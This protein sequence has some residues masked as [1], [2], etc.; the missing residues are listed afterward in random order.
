L[1]DRLGGGELMRGQHHVLVP[2]VAALVIAAGLLAT[3]GP[4]R[5]ALRVHPMEALRQQ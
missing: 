3:A 4:A 1:L 5:Q 2:M